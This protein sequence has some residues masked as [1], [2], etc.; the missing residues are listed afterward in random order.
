MGVQA[1]A[2]RLVLESDPASRRASS[3]G[4]SPPRG[5]RSRN[6]ASCWRRC[7][8]PA[9]IRPSRV[10]RLPSTTSRRSRRHRP[11]RVSPP[12]TP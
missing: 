6:C 12:R 8:L 3:P 9:A 4:S 5:T 10:D 7:A 2:A 11:R 1:G